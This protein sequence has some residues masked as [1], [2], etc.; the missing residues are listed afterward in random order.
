MIGTVETRLRR[1]DRPELVALRGMLVILAML[2]VG[3]A[4]SGGENSPALPWLIMPVAIAALRFRSQVAVLDP[5]TGLLNRSSLESCVLEI[6]QQAH[7][8]GG[9]VS[10]VLR[11]VA[12]AIRKSLRSFELVNRIGGEEF[13]V[14]LPGVALAEAVDVAERVRH[15]VLGARPGGL[16][17]DDLRRR[18]R[19]FGRRDP[20][21]PALPCC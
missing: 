7:L 10:L 20:L 16:K 15:S 12:Y 5:L 3:V 8:T 2:A 11:D 1:S 17:G 18:G 9:P 6:E 14:L 13:L 21:R 19:W 4:F